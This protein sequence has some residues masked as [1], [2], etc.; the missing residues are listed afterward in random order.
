MKIVFENITEQAHLKFK[1]GEGN[2]NLRKYEDD[3]IKIML[4]RLEPG[5]FIGLHTHEAD[6]EVVFIVEGEGRAV[7]DNVEEILKA[8]EC[9]YCPRGHAHSLINNS[10]RDLIF[11]AVVPE[12]R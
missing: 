1:G 5:A 3:T 6:C 11:Y 8:G 10:D 9:H 7:Y 4:G 2:T 12:L